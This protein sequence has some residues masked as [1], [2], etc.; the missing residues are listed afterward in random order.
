MPII[1]SMLKNTMTQHENNI[2]NN[3][4]IPNICHES[5]IISTSFHRRSSQNSNNR[6]KELFYSTS[7][8]LSF[9]TVFI[10][11]SVSGCCILVGYH[12]LRWRVRKHAIE[13]MERIRS[14]TGSEN[15]HH[16]EIGNS[17]EHDRMNDTI[18]SSSLVSGSVSTF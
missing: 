3:K 18:I 8:S 5:S 17:D 4:I 10:I 6:R 9:M 12:I 16:T 13:S 2:S 1:S 15:T 11:G 7:S 14:I